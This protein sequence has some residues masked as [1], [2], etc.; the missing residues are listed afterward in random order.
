MQNKD[1]EEVKGS[2]KDST[3]ASDKSTEDEPASAGRPGPPPKPSLQM[4]TA[5]QAQQFHKQYFSGSNSCGG[6]QTDGMRQLSTICAQLSTPGMPSWPLFVT[7]AHTC[8]AYLAMPAQSMGPSA[9][10]HLLFRC[11]AMSRATEAYLHALDSILGL[12]QGTPQ[13]FEF[14]YKYPSPSFAAYWLFVDGNG[15]LCI[16]QGKLKSC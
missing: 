11:T 9:C 4:A 14:R 5:V 1:K 3:A 12:S 6:A 16:L 13:F 15:I 10:S 2:G 8:S 7:M